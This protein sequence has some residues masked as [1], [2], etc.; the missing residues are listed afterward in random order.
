MGFALRTDVTRLGSEVSYSLTPGEE[1]NVFKHIL[2]LEGETFARHEDGSIESAQVGPQYILIFKSF[3]TLFVNPKVQFEDL[4]EPFELSDE[5]EVPEGSYT[6]YGITAVFEPAP[7][8]FRLGGGLDAGSFYDG[9]VLSAGLS[10]TW[11]LSRYLELSGEYQLNRVRFPDR[12]Q[13][14]SGDIIRLRAK[15]ALNTHLSANTFIQ[16]NSFSD[17]VGVNVR[18]RYNFSEGHDLYVVYNEALNTDRHRELPFL[19]LTD[20][21]T[22]LVKYTY[23]FVW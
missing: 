3:H 12:D 9:W 8:L 4:R 22:I 10:P 7:R 16:Y 11:T 13:R 20:T 19:P 15:A 5:V 14:F 17:A 18:L 23:T 21:R 6:F 1:S 2:A